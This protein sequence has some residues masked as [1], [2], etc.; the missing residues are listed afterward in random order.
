MSNFSRKNDFHIPFI[1]NLAFV[2]LVTVVSMISVR[3][4]LFSYLPT[5]T[6]T[7]IMTHTN[8]QIN[9]D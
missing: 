4:F 8:S 1:K 7:P 9:P 3:Y 6:N 5:M 2:G